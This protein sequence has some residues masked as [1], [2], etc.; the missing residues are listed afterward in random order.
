[1][2]TITKKAASW[3]NYQN[4]WAI[5]QT[6]FEIYQVESACIILP[7]SEYISD[8][9]EAL[10]ASKESVLSISPAELVFNQ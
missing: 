10:T 3:A 2:K 9:M 4:G 5:A 8:Q 6:Q 1:M 7:A